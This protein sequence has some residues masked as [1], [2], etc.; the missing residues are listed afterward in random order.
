MPS[1]SWPSS[2]PRLQEWAALHT[3]LIWVYRGEVH[4]S[5]RD[6]RSEDAKLTCWLLLQGT[7]EIEGKRARHKAGP[8]HWVIPP[9]CGRHQ[10]FSP[11][12]RILSLSFRVDWPGGVALYDPGSGLVV[13][14]ARFPDLARTAGRLCA[15]V[16][17]EFPGAANHLF[18]EEGSLAQHWRIHRLFADWLEAFSALMDE[19]GVRPFRP[20]ALDLRLAR[21]L[22]HIDRH[23]LN[24]PF[25]Q[26]DA[27][28]QAGLSVAQ[29]NR[30]FIRHLG[31]L[32]RDRYEERRRQAAS[33]LLTQTA[34]P[35]KAISADLGFCSP[36]HFSRWFT[37]SF[38]QPPNRFRQ[39]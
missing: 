32:P 19:S 36:A 21:A 24:R 26:R 12:A 38:G 6:L 18:L 25:R 37:R 20:E 11:E 4:A 1:N 13:P 15:E 39:S 5:G 17:K 30:V 29:L 33:L 7:V 3:Q 8:G 2:P 35:L 27:A 23:A 14:A 31:K 16:E 28:R 10:R 22:Q 34:R 9:T